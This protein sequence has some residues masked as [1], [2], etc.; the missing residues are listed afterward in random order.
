MG[1][2]QKLQQRVLES[3]FLT[4]HSA[5]FGDSNKSECFRGF[6]FP[7]CLS[8]TECLE[9]LFGSEI[10]AMG[11][12]QKG[13]RLW[14]VCS[15]E[16]GNA[17]RSNKA[18]AWSLWE[19]G[20]TQIGF[21]KSQVLI[22]IQTLTFWVAW[23]ESHV[24]LVLYLLGS[25]SD[26]ICHIVGPGTQVTIFSLINAE[27]FRPFTSLCICEY[28]FLDFNIQKGH[29]SHIFCTTKTRSISWNLK[30]WPFSL[31][32]VGITLDLKTRILTEPSGN[33]VVSFWLH[34]K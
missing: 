20:W 27:R 1:N 18:W 8:P 28:L 16:R 22:L 7:V 33:K 24:L 5:G 11:E 29:N 17:V 4:K 31:S 9:F 12:G 34:F 23:T 15:K 13:L 21:R 6:V 2:A 30:A 3:L 14:N 19:A 10:T 26:R 32:K 25:V